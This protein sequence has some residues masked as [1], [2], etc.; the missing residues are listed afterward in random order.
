M[1]NQEEFF[2][3]H[4]SAVPVIAILRGLSPEQACSLAESAW[5]SGVEL[6]EV[7]IQDDTGRNALKA[8][9]ALAHSLGKQVGAGTVLTTDDVD[10]AHSLGCSFTV[11]PGLSSTVIEA[12]QSLG[13]HHLPGVATATEVA[14]A[15]A[16]GLVWQKAF[17][18]REL[19]FGWFS[20]MHGPFPRVRFVA[21]GGV[22][23]SNFTTFLDEGAQAVGIGSA[24]SDPHVIT[25]IKNLER[26]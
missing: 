20:S 10:F 17:P 21:T 3:L 16:L 15:Q 26:T 5:N 19:G 1:L 11:A 25:V 14:T 2:D 22:D 23:A 4:L 8:V 24:L 9:A 7:P 12:A 6:V 18:A 13:L